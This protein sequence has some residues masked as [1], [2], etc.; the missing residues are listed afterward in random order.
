MTL[1][2]RHGLRAADVQRIVVHLP[3]D[4]VGIVGH[5]AMPDV[6]C[7]H[8]VALALVRGAVSFTDS[9]DASLMQNPSIRSAREKVEV[10]GDPGLMTRE[11]PRSARVEVTLTDG[12]SWNISRSFRPGP[13]RTP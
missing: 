5:S 6:N 3:T 10:V 2:E 13:R 12:R 1:R 11:A 9:H 4:A 7:Q 8:L